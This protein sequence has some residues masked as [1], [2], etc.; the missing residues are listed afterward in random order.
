MPS[1]RRRPWRRRL[2]MTALVLGLLA[3]VAWL[4]RADPVDP[5]DHFVANRPANIAHAGAPGHAPPN[6]VEGFELA[7]ELG[8]DTLEMDL[9]LSADDEVMVIHDATVDATTD[10][11]GG[12]RDMTADELRQLDA[13]YRW[14]D[15]GGEHPYRG[16]G[17]RIPTLAEVFEAFDDEFLIVEL[18]TESGIEVVD[19]VVDVIDEHD[20]SAD[21]LVAS[22]DVAFLRAFRE[23][24]P[25]VPTSIAEDEVRTFYALHRVGLHRWWRPPGHVF[26]VPE[27]HE[28]THVVTGRF[29]GAAHDLGL[30][31][32][33]W[34]VNEREDMRRLLELGVDGILTDYPDRLA[35]E[36]RRLRDQGA[37]PL[38]S[39]SAG[40]AARGPSHDRPP[41]ILRSPAAKEPG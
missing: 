2:S 11:T 5:I 27:H 34:T 20:R 31:V 9:Q 15:E 23:R 30:T 39:S 22:V 35:G 8:A 13:G 17:L 41:P 4:V 3:G 1:T 26:Q 25:D 29:V 28:G 16:Q 14:T 6:T 19:E 24:A 18:K 37:F 33:V 12:V 36:I 21:V 32:Q 38:G 10:G 7:L 40:Q